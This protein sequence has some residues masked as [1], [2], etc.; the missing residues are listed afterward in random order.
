MRTFSTFS[1]LFFLL[2]VQISAQDKSAK[3]QNLQDQIAKTIGEIKKISK[4]NYMKHYNQVEGF[5]HGL[6]I[7]STNGEIWF[8]NYDMGLK[9][10]KQ[11]I[12]YT[13][14][15]K[16]IEANYDQG[17]LIDKVTF[18]DPQGGLLWT[19]EGIEPNDSIVEIKREKAEG[20]K[21]YFT[22]EKYRYDYRVYIKKYMDNGLLYKEGYGL[23]DKDWIFTYFPVGEWIYNEE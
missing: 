3:I 13:G 2:V 10:G 7:E 22:K 15:M 6:W 17:E 12:Y 19:Y 23:I 21:I 8:T 14:G 11:T 4:V 20:N 5:K 18:Y 9:H 1:L 16:Y